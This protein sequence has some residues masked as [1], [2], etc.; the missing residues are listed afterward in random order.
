VWARTDTWTKA[1]VVD[2][3]RKIMRGSVGHMQTWGQSGARRV[4]MV[5]EGMGLEG[6]TGSVG[7]WL[8]GPVR[9]LASLGDG[10]MCPSP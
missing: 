7:M 6:N 3:L 2:L 5:H 4:R 8:V 9:W 10:P 1:C